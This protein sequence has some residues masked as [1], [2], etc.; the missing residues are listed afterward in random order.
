MTTT[1]AMC[2]GLI[3]LGSPVKSTKERYGFGVWRTLYHYEC[4]VCGNAVKVWC[5]SYRGRHPQPGI[6]GIRCTWPLSMAN[7]EVLS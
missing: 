1:L 7:K 4:P 2:P 6:G 3:N 5:N